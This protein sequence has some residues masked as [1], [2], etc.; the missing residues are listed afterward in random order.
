MS[1]EIKLKTEKEIQKIVDDFDKKYKW[2][3]ILK[4]YQPL[5]IKD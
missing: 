4:I 2:N 1:K 3:D 5:P